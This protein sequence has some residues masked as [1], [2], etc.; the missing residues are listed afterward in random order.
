[1]KTNKNLKK[2]LTNRADSIRYKGTDAM[3]LFKDVLSLII[4]RLSFSSGK[5][6]FVLTC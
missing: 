4:N 2:D 1:M 6:F 3:I 5:S